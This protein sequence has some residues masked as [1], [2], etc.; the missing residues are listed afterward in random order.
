MYG[1]G[2]ITGSFM[3]GYLTDSGI[4]IWCFGLKAGLGLIIVLVSC[5][6]DKSLEHDSNDLINA[7]LINRSK[8]NT[9]DI[10]K[11]LKLPELW[12]SILYYLLIG[13]M[14][15]NFAD[16]Y[17]YYQIEIAGFTN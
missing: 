7:T 17:Y 4:E 3:G 11:G 5:S 12:K 1:L 8:S 10:I 16:Y 9:K 15:P 14:V 13:A 2:G 6:M